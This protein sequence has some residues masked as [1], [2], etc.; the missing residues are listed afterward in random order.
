M[1]C[2]STLREARGLEGCVG[3][4]EHGGSPK[5]GGGTF[6]WVPIIR[7]ILYWVPP[8][9]G[10]YHT[11]QERICSRNCKSADVHAAVFAEKHSTSLLKKCSAQH[12]ELLP[13]LPACL[14]QGWVWSLKRLLAI[15]QA[16]T[17]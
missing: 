10:N 9:S 3:A 1:Y 2:A 5:G 7:T 14:T 6:L 17:P 13:G 12:F 4:D 16:Q 15:A 11:L 8:I